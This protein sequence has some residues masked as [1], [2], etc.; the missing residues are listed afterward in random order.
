M[1]VDVLVV[2]AGPTG[3]TLACELAVRGVRCRI[4]DRAPAFFGGS[5]ADGI[6]PRTL[7]IFADIGV[8][9]AVLAAGDLGIEMR[10]YQGEEVVWSGRMTEPTAPTPS[11]PFP[12]IWFVPQFRTEEILRTRLSELGVQVELGVELTDFV[13]DAD[14]VTATL[15]GAEPV[16]ARYLVGADGG[17]STVRRTLG[18]A[19]P[20]ETDEATTTLFADARVDGVGRDHGRIWQ[21]GDGGVAIV[22]LAG[23]ELFVVTARPPTD[24]GEPI[25]DYLQCQ[26]TEATGR[27]DIVV[28]EVTWHT[29]WR[30][31]TRLA[32][33]FREGR[34]LLAG[35]AGHV[36]PPTGGQGMNTGIQDAYNRGWKL[37]ATLDGAPPAVLD[38]YELERMAAA[39]AALD[40]STGLLEKHRRGDAD[41]HVRGPEVH[42]LAFGYRGGPLSRD[43]RAAP[44]A[45]RAGDR[46]PDAPVATADGRSIRLFDLFRGPHWTL[47]VFGSADVAA[48]PAQLPAYAV[49]RPGQPV[50]EHTVVDV[51]GH[52]RA[53]YDAQDGIAVLVRPDGYVGMVTTLDG[54]DRLGSYEGLAV[55]PRAPSPRSSGR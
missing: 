16:R 7:E 1:D 39:R 51:E 43:D 47:L 23:T 44:G 28:R 25:R 30:A 36:H 27:S 55:T 41:A 9:D 11:V 52:A 31:N 29:T 6:Q 12:N 33:R 46:A 20:G 8:L 18:I 37:A 4:V 26:V 3:L 45:L 24:A 22:P 53:A 21:V 10:A 50:D 32:E 5:R 13:Q 40:I 2:G 34:V 48:L 42:G 19:F 38:S 35:D 54:V 15:S 17:R 14:G 49:V